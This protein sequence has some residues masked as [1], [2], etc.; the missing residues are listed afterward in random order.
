MAYARAD[1][2]RS[3]TSA[4]QQAEEARR[5]ADVAKRKAE[6]TRARYNEL[7]KKMAADNL[8]DPN[9]AYSIEKKN[10][11]LYINGAQQSSAVMDKYQSYLK[12][13]NTITI[14][15]EKDNLNINIQD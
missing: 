2:K 7:V 1:A 3:A 14:K 12:E 6:V 8:L 9:K 11:Q 4:H 10:G 15:G 13:G 5:Q